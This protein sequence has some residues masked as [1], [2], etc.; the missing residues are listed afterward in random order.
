MALTDAQVDGLWASIVKAEGCQWY[1]DK[2]HVCGALPIAGKHYCAEHYARAYVKGS[3]LRG[4][5]KARAIEKDLAEV[6]LKD[7]IAIDEAD[8]E[9]VEVAVEVEED[10]G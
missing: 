3:A 4:K 1:G 8:V 5:K 10:F 6:A 9:V 2:D 7:Q